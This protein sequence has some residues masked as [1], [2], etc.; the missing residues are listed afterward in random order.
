[1]KPILQSLTLLFWALLLSPL[2]FLVVIVILNS[3]GFTTATDP[4]FSSILVYMA[5]GYVPLAIFLSRYL[6]QNKLKAI[7]AGGDLVDKLAEYRTAWILGTA[8]LEGSIILILVVY[9]LSQQKLLLGAVALV[10]AFQYLRRPT[11]EKI[12]TD[13]NLPAEEKRQ[14]EEAL[15]S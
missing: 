14:I 5:L 11:S 1:M 6:S 9:L 7:D 10:W 15:Q 3:Q 4:S 2:V 12:S 8:V 13:L